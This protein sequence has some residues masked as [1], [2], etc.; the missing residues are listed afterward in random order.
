MR[1][2]NFNLKQLS[3]VETGYFWLPFVLF[4]FRHSMSN[5]FD[6]GQL[7]KAKGTAVATT[8]TR[9]IHFEHH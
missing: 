2:L 6:I 8:R 5:M 1:V 9:A 7:A 3:M 4:F